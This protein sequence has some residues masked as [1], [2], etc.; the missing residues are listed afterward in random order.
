MF[1]K[2]RT[3]IYRVNDIKSAKDWYKNATG[4]DPYFDEPFYVGFDINDSEQ[5]FDPVNKNITPGNQ[6]A[7]SWSVDDTEQVCNHLVSIGGKIVQPKTNVGSSICVAIIE[8][9]FGNQPGSIEG[10]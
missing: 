1:K 2:L 7:A 8:D 5:R 6:S 9:P 10:A 3:V 4:T